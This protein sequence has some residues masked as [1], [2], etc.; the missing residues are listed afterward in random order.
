MVAPGHEA[1]CRHE[2]RVSGAACCS[3]AVLNADSTPD[4]R[5]L[6]GDASATSIDHR[7]RAVDAVGAMA[8][9]SNLYQQAA[10]AAS[11]VNN[12]TSPASGKVFDP[13]EGQ[14]QARVNEMIREG[15]VRGC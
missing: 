8:V 12:K 10:I 13:R 5:G 14:V 11:H 3:V 7:L 4:L 9:P 2:I 6:A 1:K 15:V